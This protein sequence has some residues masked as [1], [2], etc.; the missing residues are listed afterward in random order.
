MKTEYKVRFREE[1]PALAIPQKMNVGF[2]GTLRNS[3]MTIYES[4]PGAEAVMESILQNQSNVASFERVPRVLWGDADGVR[5]TRKSAAVREARKQGKDVIVRANLNGRGNVYFVASEEEC[6]V[7]VA[8][9]DQVIDDP[10][11]LLQDHDASD[12]FWVC[13]DGEIYE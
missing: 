1:S 9:R 13:D 10:E 2:E 5:Y 11:E 8:E 3:L 12:Q 7:H 4:N 6:V